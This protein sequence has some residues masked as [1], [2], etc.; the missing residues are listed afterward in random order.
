MRDESVDF[1]L[2]FF[3]PFHSEEFYRVI[4]P[5]GTLVT[6]IPGKRHLF[7]LKQVL[8]DT[9]YENDEALPDIGQFKITRKIKVKDKITL[10]GGEDMLSLLQMTPYYYHTPTEGINKLCA[11]SS[12]T[13]EI[14]FV[15]VCCEK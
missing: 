4:K 9:P 8:Y 7:G 2:H 13:T 11:L 12:L 5:G 6:A 1:A 3:A 10:T 14:E 15:L